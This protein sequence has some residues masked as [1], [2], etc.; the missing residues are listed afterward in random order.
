MVCGQINAKNAFGAYAG[1]TP[2]KIELDMKPKGFFSKGVSYSVV[3][4]EIFTEKDLF[5]AVSFKNICGA[6]E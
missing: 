1:Y 5:D 4:K 6:D 2:F 3:S